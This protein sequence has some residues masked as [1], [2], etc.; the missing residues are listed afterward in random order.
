MTSSSEHRQVAALDGFAFPQLPPEPAVTTAPRAPRSQPG[1]APREQAESI[2]N[3]AL[4]EADRIREVARAEGYE[5]GVRAA[6]VEAAERFESAFAA[7]SEAVTQARDMRAR[8]A[9]DVERHAVEL[10]L[11]VAE[12]ALAGALSAQPERVVDVVRGAL[13]C[14][15]ERERVVILVNPDDL[16]A[17]RDA[18]G[19]LVRSL[20][21]IEHCEVQEERRVARGG[22]VVRSATGEIDANLSTK[23]DRAREVLEA[24][25]SG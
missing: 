6:T 19:D 23:L 14:L 10:G 11:Q 18:V 2:V 20:G 4:A 3:A 21:G 25:L 5:S 12:K 17:V 8:T 16:E 7:L 13:R 22:A 24:E 15:V 9:D 1:Q